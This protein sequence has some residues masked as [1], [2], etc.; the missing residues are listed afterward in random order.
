MQ[1]VIPGSLYFI[2][3]IK[4]FAKVFAGSLDEYI[5]TT[6]YPK[7]FYFL[8]DIDLTN[9]LSIIAKLYSRLFKTES[10]QVCGCSA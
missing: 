3:T 8:L 2:L 10:F 4:V 7:F 5:A 9:C 6:I 1:L